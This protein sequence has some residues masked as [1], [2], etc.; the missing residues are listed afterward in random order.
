MKVAKVFRKYKGEG[1]CVVG[2]LG[3]GKDCAPHSGE[4]SE[5]NRLKLN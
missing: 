2:V 5:S 3:I 4:S 1:C